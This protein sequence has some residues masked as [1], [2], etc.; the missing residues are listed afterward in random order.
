MI[1]HDASVWP[2]PHA[3]ELWMVAQGFVCVATL[4]A[5]VADIQF[6]PEHNIWSLPVVTFCEQN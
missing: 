2:P 1:V 6:L 3:G 5:H 4:L